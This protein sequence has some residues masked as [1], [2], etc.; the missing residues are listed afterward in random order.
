MDPSFMVFAGLLV[1]VVCIFALYLNIA[2]SI[3]LAMTN[4][5]GRGKKIA[6]GVLVWVIPVLGAL[7]VLIALSV[8][9]GR[10]P[11]EFALG[12]R[13]RGPRLHGGAHACGADAEADGS[14][15]IFDGGDGGADGGFGVF[16][17]DGGG[18]GGDGG[19]GG[20]G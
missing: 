7:Y 4:K 17:G 19:G 3:A 9:R 20:G 6:K 15:E 14:G 2:A 10:A 12:P 13:D 18:F 5:L 16:G 1:I 8:L 11:L